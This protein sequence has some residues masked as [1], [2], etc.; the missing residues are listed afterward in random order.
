MQVKCRV[1]GTDTKQNRTNF[2]KYKVDDFEHAA[3]V[4][5]E[6]NYE[7][8]G[9]VILPVSDVLAMVRPAGHVKWNDVE[10]HTNAICIKD[11]LQAISGE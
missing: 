7:I 6:D 10:S 9:A 4:I 3:I 11:Q 1:D 8:S 2:G 5:F